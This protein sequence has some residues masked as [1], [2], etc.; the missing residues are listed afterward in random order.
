MNYI[1]KLYEDL[2]DETFL[3]DFVKQVFFNGK[4]L[5][6]QIV[7]FRTIKFD[8]KEKNCVQFKILLNTQPIKTYILASFAEFGIKYCN[9]CEYFG[10]NDYSEPNMGI[11]QDSK[12][13]DMKRNYLQYMATHYEGYQEDCINNKIAIKEKEKQKELAW[14]ESVFA[15]TQIDKL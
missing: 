1:K 12:I 8:E 15:S 5:D 6:F 10:K 3:Y 14:L 4:E 2:Q 7:N 11:I 13:L 9:E